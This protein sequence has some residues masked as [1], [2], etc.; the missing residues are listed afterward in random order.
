MKTIAIK[1]QKIRA[2]TSTRYKQYRRFT[3]ICVENTYEKITETID[4]EKTRA[5]TRSLL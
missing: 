4:K 2:I 3:A 1:L 5:H